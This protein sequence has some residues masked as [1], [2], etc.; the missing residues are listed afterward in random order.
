MRTEQVASELYYLK[1]QINPH[2]LFNSLNSIYALTV[3]KSD[4]APEAVI[5]LSELMRYMLYET[6]HHFVP[7]EKELQ[8]IENYIKLQRLRM[9]DS[10][11]VTLKVKGDI[12]NKKISPLILI[13]FIENAFKYGVNSSGKTKI[14]IVLTLSNDQISFHCDNAISN[15]QK[16]KNTPE[17]IG[18]KNTKERLDLLYSNKYSLE[19]VHTE[20][21][22]SVDLKLDI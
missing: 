16:D 9:A 3:K 12:T 11:N 6:D 13:S 18:L 2:F 21:N 17:G 14:N 8:Y 19:I 22:Y 1:N 15:T 10:S 5:T 7:V 4:Q 20:D